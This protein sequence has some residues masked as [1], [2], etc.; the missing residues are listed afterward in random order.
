MWT[1]I[2]LDPVEWC[3]WRFERVTGWDETN[4]YSALSAYARGM[5]R[6]SLAPRLH[7]QSAS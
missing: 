6:P 7:T 1:A 3:R 5:A 4:F 2:M